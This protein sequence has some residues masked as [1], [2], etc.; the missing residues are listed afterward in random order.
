MRIRT[1]KPAFWQSETI[2]LLDD[3]T[4]LVFIG[5]WNYVDDHGKGIDNAALVRAALFPLEDRTLA[6][7]ER[8]LVAIAG[9]G[10]ICR[11]EAGGKRLLHVCSWREHQK[12]NRPY[13]SGL[14]DPVH[15]ARSER[16]VNGHGASCPQDALSFEGSVREMDMDRERDA[17]REPVV[18][19]LA[20]ARRARGAS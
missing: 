3:T 15:C 18:S 9:A 10:L 7:L 20:E 12:V 1:I 4:R 13:P 2:A 16:A 5:L 14:P 6:E 19:D 11:Y 17:A 8:C